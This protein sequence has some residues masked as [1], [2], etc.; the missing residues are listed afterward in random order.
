MTSTLLVLLLL[1]QAEGPDDAPA[2]AMEP[3]LSA[4]PAGQ[5][6]YLTRLEATGLALLPRAGA[7]AEEAF[8]QMEPTLIVD[9]GAEFGLNLG[10]PV[11][12]R[13]GGGGEG[14][15]L[16]RREDW[17]SLSDWGSSC[18]A[19]SWA[20]TPRRWPSGWACWRATASCPAH[21]GPPLL[22]PGQPRLPPG[23]RLPHR[24]AGAPLRG[25][26]RLGRAG[27]ASRWARRSALDCSTSSSA[28]PQAAR[29]LHAGAVRRA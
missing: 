9:G 2:G 13:L 1:S 20:R 12:L 10:A 27:R 23:G 18:A 19:S 7:G 6:R 22:Q 17:D 11:R 4:A 29:A 21:L 3:P 24:H 28:K 14:A 16:V 26:L 15:G 5:W 8:A 25:G